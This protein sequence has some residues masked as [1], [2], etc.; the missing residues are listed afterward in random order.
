MINPPRDFM[1]RLALSNETTW[2]YSTTVS[3]RW[4]VK[5]KQLHPVSQFPSLPVVVHLSA[6]L[7]RQWARRRTLWGL[8]GLGHGIFMTLFSHR[9]DEW[10][11]PV[12]WHIFS[13]LIGSPSSGSCRNVTTEAC[14]ECIRRLQMSTLLH[15]LSLARLRWLYF[16]SRLPLRG[17]R[18]SPH[19]PANRPRNHADRSC[20]VIMRTP[21]PFSAP[22]KL[23]N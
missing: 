4:K 18:H 5:K 3:A 9:P 1:M 12:I 13:P 16:D 19:S 17:R 8:Y 2:K 14:S 15:L 22:G 11:G 7:C 20:L 6:A 10:L 23:P 21:F